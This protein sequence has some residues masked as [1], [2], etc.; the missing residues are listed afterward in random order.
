MRTAAEGASEEE[1]R[2]DVD[3]LTATW[4]DIKAKASSS[5]TKAPALLHGEPD[6][7]VRVIRD[8]FNE[9]FASL[10]VA[11]EPAWSPGQRLRQLRRAR[12]RRPGHQVDR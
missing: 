12:P 11:G 8:V 7:T 9:D 5:Q 10:V 6:L 2:A 1:L 3:R 4:E